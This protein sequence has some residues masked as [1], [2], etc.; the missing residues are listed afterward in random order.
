M[1]GVDTIF[2]LNKTIT[3]TTNMGIQDRTI[4][5]IIAFSLVA[6][7]LADVIRGT[8]GVIALIVAGIFV[9]TSFFGRCPLYSLFRINSK[10]KKI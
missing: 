3:M 2:V 6:L 7:Y 5:L 10:P 4:R 9:V 1:A 8:W